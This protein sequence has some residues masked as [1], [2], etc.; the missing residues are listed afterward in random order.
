VLS[1]LWQK[2]R[3][4]DIYNVR[5]KAWPIFS[6]KKQPPNTIS[7]HITNVIHIIKGLPISS[8]VQLFNS[9]MA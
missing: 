1:Y 4:Y 3:G 7:H 8:R 2:I 5:E 6:A 9:T